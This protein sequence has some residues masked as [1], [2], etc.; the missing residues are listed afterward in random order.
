MVIYLNERKIKG[1]KGRL[2]LFYLVRIIECLFRA[3]IGIGAIA[4]AMAFSEMVNSDGQRGTPAAGFLTLA[5][6]ITGLVYLVSNTIAAFR[7]L[8]KSF[9]HDRGVFKSLKEI[10]PSTATIF[11]VKLVGLS[12]LDYL[13]FAIKLTTKMTVNAIWHL[14][15]KRD[16]IRTGPLTS[17][18]TSVA[19]N[20][21][22]YRPSS[23]GVGFVERQIVHCTN[24]HRILPA[25]S[26]Y[27]ESNPRCNDCYFA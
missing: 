14:L 27:D 16:L 19:E 21:D 6:M 22:S 11:V 8:P 2:D 3:W 26:T 17:S 25:G 7:L 20:G 1:G 9:K 24:C 15:F 10:K 4:S 12:F 18:T 5:L 23:K 13:W